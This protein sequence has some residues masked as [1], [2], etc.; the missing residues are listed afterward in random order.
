MKN[1]FNLIVFVLLSF[2]FTVCAQDNPE[3]KIGFISD[4][5]F[6]YFHSGPG[7]QYRILGSIDSGEE[8]QVISAEQNGY[9]QIQ[10]SQNRN[11]WIDAK[12]LSDSPGLRVVLAELNEDIT[13]KAMQISSLKEKLAKT[14]SD[15]TQ[16]KSQLALIKKD[17]SSIEKQFAEVS[18][19]LDE[20][21]FDIKKTWFIYGASVLIIGLLLGLIIPKFTGKK[22][23]YSSWK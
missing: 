18:S 13:D 16:L 3:A 10:D 9:I 11:G 6:T 7:T 1:L 8:V 14:S 15:L 4:D 2:T 12:Y 23:S 5:L 20:Q 22:S 21:A 17:K 19:E